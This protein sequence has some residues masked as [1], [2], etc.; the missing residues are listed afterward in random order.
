MKKNK[1]FFFDRDGILNKSII[2]KKKPYSPR[3]PYELKLNHKFLPFIE[4]LK[5]KKFIIIVV[6]NQ[7]DIKRGK[8]KKYTSKIINSIIKKYFLVDEVFVCEHDKID[9]CD[10][11]KPKPGMLKNAMKRWNIDIKKSF[12][13][14]DRIKDI[15]AGNSV[16][17][18]TIFI[19][20][21]Y[22]E[23]KPKNYDYKFTSISK[24]IKVI[25]KII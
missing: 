6:T 2:K 8:L 5:K 11:R 10:C 3:Y 15:E 4:D 7:P 22:D 1:A 16:G 21:N 24:M 13:V 17:C 19:D 20:Y 12:L 25:G 23:L 18:T 9:N 14:G